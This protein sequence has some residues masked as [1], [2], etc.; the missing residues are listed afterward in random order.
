MLWVGAGADE[1]EEKSIPGFE[2][3][4]S[5]LYCGDAVHG[6]M[7]Q[8]TESSVRLVDASSLQLIAQWPTD[9]AASITV[10]SA[11]YSQASV[12]LSPCLWMHY[13]ITRMIAVHQIVVAERG[14][15]VNY[16]EIGRGT[17]SLK[18]QVRLEHE[19]ACLDITPFEGQQNAEVWI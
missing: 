13:V 17:L 11:N 7:L 12:P 4:K 1:L 10:A 6:Q 15:K 19:V 3:E 5:S 8:V 9:A 18:R 14:G 16:I 2:S